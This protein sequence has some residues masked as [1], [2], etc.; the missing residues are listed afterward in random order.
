[1]PIL[2]LEV[3]WYYGDEDDFMALAELIRTKYSLETEN[4]SKLQRAYV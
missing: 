3:E 4:M 1:V 2:E